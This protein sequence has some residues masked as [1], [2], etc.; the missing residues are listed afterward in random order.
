MSLLN[1]ETELRA[2]EPSLFNRFLQRMPAP[3]ERGVQT[4]R[5]GFLG[6]PKERTVQEHIQTQTGLTPSLRSS[7]T[8][9]GYIPSWGKTKDEQINTAER[10]F[11]KAGFE[12]EDAERY[13]VAQVYGKTAMPGSVFHEEFQNVREEWKDRED[14]HLAERASWRIST[15]KNIWDTLDALAILPIGQI[16]SKAPKVVQYGGKTLNQI[17]FIGEAKRFKT[18]DEFIKGS[19]K[20]DSFS[21]KQ[22]R[23]IWENSQLL[24][25]VDYPNPRI[26]SM[27]QMMTNPKTELF[28]VTMP[29]GVKTRTITSGDFINTNFRDIGGLYGGKSF[30][31]RDAFFAIDNFD[32]NQVAQRGD[33]GAGVKSFYNFKESEA[34]MI[35]WAD[36]YMKQI[37]GI[38]KGVRKKDQQAIANFRLGLSKEPLSPKLQTVNKKLTEF[39]DAI[40]N[41]YNAY[42]KKAGM[43]E[44][45]YIENYLTKKMIPTKPVVGGADEMASG[46]TKQRIG[47]ELPG[48]QE[49]DLGKI[50]ATYTSNVGRK[51]YLEAP[52]EQMKQVSRVLR[53]QHGIARGSKFID[54]FVNETVSPEIVKSFTTNL[55]EVIIGARSTAALAFNP[56]WTATVQPL[57]TAMIIGR[58]PQ[59]RAFGKGLAQMFSK[60][61]RKWHDTLST[62]RL[63]TDVPMS[64]AGLGDIGATGMPRGIGSV[65]ETWNRTV[66]IFAD[67]MESGLSRLA[68]NTARNYGKSKGLKGDALDI[69]ADLMI[70]ATQSEYLRSARP[71]MMRN[72]IVRLL[73][74]FQTWSFEAYRFSKTLAGAPGGLPIHS[75]AE[76]LKQFVGFMGSVAAMDWMQSQI[77]GRR[78]T[79]AGSFTPVVG[80]AT[81]KAISIATK[82]LGMERTEKALVG[83]GGFGRTPVS[84]WDDMEALEKATDKYVNDGDIQP[85][86]K[87]LVKWGMGLSRIAGA[88]QVNRSIDAILA[89]KYGVKTASG[90][91]AFQLSGLDRVSAHFT[92]VYGTKAGREYLKKSKELWEK[93]DEQ[94]DTQKNITK[95]ARE[96]YELIADLMEESPEEAE[97]AYSDIA[98]AYPKIAER[99]VKIQ[100]EK[101]AQLTSNDKLLRQLNVENWMRAE[102]IW[103]MLNNA[104]SNKERD[105][106]WKKYTEVSPRII[107]PRVAEQIKT[108][109]E[110]Q[111][112]MSIT[113]IETQLQMWRQQITP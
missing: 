15:A 21:K 86:R 23:A 69:Y 12:P 38:F 102:E 47:G 72:T 73:A 107:S 56:L 16:L 6:S 32:I 44:I 18:A 83:E 50:L 43:S 48:I 100:E 105:E 25:K 85:F 51:M 46:F 36:G 59:A 106:M 96:E 37:R 80:T 55:A 75:K 81:D 68:A 5:E 10:S 24:S 39:T 35:R 57:S 42:A 84:I 22:L 76:R 13:A 103:K 110:R 71:E 33:W 113:E 34:Q 77:T 87:L 19:A 67:S 99:M 7:F 52:L 53:E 109:F 112:T 95:L 28:K 41:D 40:R 29:D 9:G 3:I 108:L 74:P 63:K 26:P 8:A 30:N 90:D 70:G 45:G 27:R 4:I 98:T 2:S 58:N 97:E 14:G 61:S 93:I 66:G 31:A 20:A 88:S 82:A 92:G 89:N 54:D 49:T 111:E 1:R 62:F 60:S 79:T 104:E 94:R 65:R 64:V 78:V 91:E 11:L 17:D 101:E